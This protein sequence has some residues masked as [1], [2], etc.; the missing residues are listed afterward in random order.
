MSISISPLVR[1]MLLKERVDKSLVRDISQP[2][3]RD[4]WTLRFGQDWVPVDTVLD[5]D[6]FYAALMYVLYDSQHLEK[7][8]VLSENTAYVRLRAFGADPY[9]DR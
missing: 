5:G 3:M 7:H 6:P 2:A 8:D 4:L 1:S 9:A